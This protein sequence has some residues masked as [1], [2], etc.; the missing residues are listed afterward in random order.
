MKSSRK[1]QNLV[2]ATIVGWLLL[3][4]FLPNLMIIGTSFLTRN[5]ANLV[6]MVFTLDNY[7]RLFDP[8]YAQ[9]ML[10]SFN[11]A[12]IATVC[13]L[14]IGYLV[15]SFGIFLIRQNVDT[16][17]PD[18]LIEAARID[19]ASEW[20]IFWRIALPLLRG[21]LAALGVLAFFQAWT[22]FAWPMI[23]ATKR[24]A[25]ING[26]WLIWLKF[27]EGGHK[28][29]PKHGFGVGWQRKSAAK[30]RRD[31]TSSLC[32]LPGNNT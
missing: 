27:A 2:I 9:V 30:G 32:T 17:I 14:L 19:G 4:V 3:F 18:E 8:M 16:A 20:W 13:C 21:P 26:A 31:R 5:D 22:A 12:V 11:M 29:T 6:D 23:V 15:M 1:F 25:L 7:R 10:H 28:K 24:Q